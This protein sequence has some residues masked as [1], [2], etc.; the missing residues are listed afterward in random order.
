MPAFFDYLRN[1]TYYLLFAALVGMLAPGGKYQQY[2]RLVTG[3]VLLFLLIQPL[4][5]F[6]KGPGIPVTQWFMD[7]VPEADTNYES[8]R[9]SL[10]RDAF[11]EQ[12][13]SQL[14]VL[15]QQNNYELIDAEFVYTEDFS[16]IEGLS[17]IVQRHTAKQEK[18]PFIRIE[19]IRIS[20]A[21]ESDSGEEA[22]A[23]KKLISGFYNLS[24]TH[25]HVKIQM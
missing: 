14:A 5:A 20:D 6:V 13:N 25:I 23:V 16:R 1:I 7:A 17:L 8:L 11:E 21:P 4:T 10:L 19:P 9:V 15:L 22:E 24:V 3:L 18:R 2:V 12:L